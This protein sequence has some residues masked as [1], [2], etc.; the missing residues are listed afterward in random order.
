MHD[1]DRRLLPAS[2]LLQVIHV[3]HSVRAEF[4]ARLPRGSPR[5]ARGRHSS[6]RPGPRGCFETLLG[7]HVAADVYP[8]R[9]REDAFR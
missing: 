5:R 6:R 9:N 2:I 1:G 4:M 7:G 8:T 3:G